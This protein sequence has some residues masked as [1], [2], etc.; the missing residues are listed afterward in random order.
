M[1]AASDGADR[2]A[3]QQQLLHLEAVAGL[4]SKRFEVLRQTLDL[5]CAQRLQS[6]SRVFSKQRATP[7][8]AV[9]A[10]ICDKLKGQI[11]REN[12]CRPISSATS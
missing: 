12:V 5:S 9:D 8:N 7:P 6:I 11:W 2:E 3:V 4:Q 1:L 10:D